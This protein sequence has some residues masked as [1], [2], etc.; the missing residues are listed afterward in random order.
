MAQ[1]ILST[2][3]NIGMQMATNTKFRKAGITSEL[4]EDWLM[5][6]KDPNFQTYHDVWFTWSQ[7]RQGI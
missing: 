6:R 1:A 7:K 2:L 4:Q 3:E 5:E